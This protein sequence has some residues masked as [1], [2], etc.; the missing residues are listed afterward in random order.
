VFVAVDEVDVGTEVQ[1]AAAELAEA[2]YDQSLRL[3][4][5]RTHGTVTLRELGFQ[6][7]QRD[8]QAG[9]GQARAA[10]QRGVD[11]VE[12]EH[13]AP[14]QSRGFGLA[15]AAQ[16]PWP[17]IAVV[18]GQR[19][20]R[21]RRSVVINGKSREQIRLRGEYFDGEIADERNAAQLRG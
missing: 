5:S 17:L 3:A 13:V 2:E 6:R 20:W 19:R 11:I 4:C 12:A 8:P 7:F 21:R 15:V 1:L 9:L 18:G 16:Q 14:D 10:G